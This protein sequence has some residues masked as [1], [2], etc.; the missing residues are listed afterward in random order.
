LRFF[1]PYL[2]TAAWAKPSSQPSSP[3]TAS[4]AACLA[5]RPAYDSGWVD[6]GT[7]ESHPI[8]IELIHNPGG[9]LV[10]YLLDLKCWDDSGM[11]TY[12]CV[13][14]NFLPKSYRISLLRLKVIML[15]RRLIL[16]AIRNYVSGSPEV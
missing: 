9:D 10:S 7:H 12:N 2:P 13:D 5:V 1:A 8:N 11:A 14:Q 4:T 15:K 3:P 6:T 16:L